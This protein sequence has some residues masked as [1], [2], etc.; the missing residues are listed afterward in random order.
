[1][2][3]C[4]PPPFPADR[5]ALKDLGLLQGCWRLGRATQAG[6][7]LKKG[8]SELCAVPT[9]RICFGG[10][11]SGKREITVICPSKGTIR[12]A[13]PITGRFG[14]DST[15]GTAQPRVDCQPA[16]AY[17]KGAPN[18]NLTCH[19]ISDTLVICRDRGNVEHEFQRE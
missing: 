5:W 18:N 4:K 16:T 9:G 6:F 12:C 17:W 3:Q 10:D 11:G 8:E 2:E 14:S 7:D 13:A 1:V 15:F 19:R